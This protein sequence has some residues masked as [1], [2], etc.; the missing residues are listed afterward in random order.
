M[1]FMQAVK[2]VYSNY[3]NFQDR[4]GRGEYWWFILFYFAA[5]FVLAI[6]EGM[7]GFSGILTNIFA[8]GTLIPSIAV[9]VRR[10]HDTGH[11]GWWILLNLIPLIGWIILIIMSY[12]KPSEGPN[13]YGAAPLGA[14]PTNPSA[15]PEAPDL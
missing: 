12:A 3:V 13:Q 14:T 7:L 1:D 8:L 11:S 10:L 2:S 9:G 15:D 4:S 6:L 5:Y